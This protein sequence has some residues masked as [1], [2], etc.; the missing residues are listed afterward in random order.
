MVNRWSLIN[1]LPSERKSLPI[2]CGIEIGK[3]E[4]LKDFDLSSR[5]VKEKLA[6]RYGSKIPMEEYVISPE[7]IYQ[8]DQLVTIMKN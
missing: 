8:S 3:L 4:R 1:I 5:P 7:S 2:R 6:E